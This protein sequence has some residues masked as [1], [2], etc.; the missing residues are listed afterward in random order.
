MFLGYYIAMCWT[1]RD[2]KIRVDADLARET[3]GL[4]SK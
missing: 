2:G 3:V 1:R 4:H